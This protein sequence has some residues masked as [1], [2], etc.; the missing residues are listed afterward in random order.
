M[1]ARQMGCQSCLSDPRAFVVIDT[2]VAINLI[3]TRIAGPILDAVPN[4]VSVVEEV[5]IELQD[6][7]KCGRTEADALEKLVASG[8]MN[9]VQLGSPAIND[10]TGLVSGQAAETLDDGE[11]ATIAYALERGATALIDERKANRI[12]A[13]RFP[14]L[15]IGCTVDLLAHD[16]LQGALGPDGLSDAVFNALHDGRMRVLARHLEWIVRL[17]GPERAAKC[18]SLPASIRSYGDP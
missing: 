10:F 13:E 16:S 12:C 18:V 4:Q 15:A 5:A 11:A 7:R 17:V 1:G 14:S 6:G 3:A 2:S 9:I 8:R